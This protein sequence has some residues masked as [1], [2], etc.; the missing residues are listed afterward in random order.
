M[1]GS[2]PVSRFDFGSPP[3][4]TKTQNT[5]GAGNGFQRALTRRP[6]PAL[7]LYFALSVYMFIIQPVLTLPSGLRGLRGSRK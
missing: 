4:T 1:N 2:S 3:Q 7:L 6:F 5:W